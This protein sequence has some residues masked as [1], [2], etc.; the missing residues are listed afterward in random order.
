[1][2]SLSVLRAPLITVVCAA[3]IVACT[4]IVSAENFPVSTAQANP[5]DAVVGD[6]RPSDMNVEVRI[7]PA[8]GQYLA[9]IVKADN[10]EMVNKEIMRGI[11]FDP[12]TKTWRGEVFAFKRGEFV[13]MSITLTQA[14]FEMVAGSGFMSKTVEWIRV[15]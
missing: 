12:N 5:A 13:P 4:S 8:N 9:A 2:S 11:T 6:W 10:Q 15:R 7:F 1:M 3:G 14:G